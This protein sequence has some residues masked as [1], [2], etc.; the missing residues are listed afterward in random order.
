VSQLKIGD[1]SGETFEGFKMLK[2]SINATTTQLL[3]SGEIC[4]LRYDTIPFKSAPAN[5]FSTLKTQKCQIVSCDTLVANER[6]V[7]MLMLMLISCCEGGVKN[8]IAMI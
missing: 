4:K 6:Y 1:F 7:E 5:V 2:F 3:A 8:F